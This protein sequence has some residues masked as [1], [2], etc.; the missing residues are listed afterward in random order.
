MYRNLHLRNVLKRIKVFFFDRWW[1]VRGPAFK[2]PPVPAAVSS[3]VFIC[4]GN[5][6]RSAFAHY[7]VSQALQNGE[8]NALRVSSAGLSARTGT[9][10]PE[11]AI[12]AAKMFSIDMGPHRASLLTDDM[13]AAADMLIAMEPGQVRAMQK[14]YPHRK[15]NIFLLPLFAED[16]DRNYFGWRR[17]HIQD[18]YGRSRDEFVASFGRVRESVDGLMGR[19]KN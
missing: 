16:W 19:L 12:Q 5:I 15:E 11:M 7:L 14:R 17:Y 18:P 1:Q 10:S 13:A 4:K 8:R 6:C 3:V 2:N 9:R